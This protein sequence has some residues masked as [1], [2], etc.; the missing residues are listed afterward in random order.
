MDWMTLAVSI[1]SF[2]SM[3]T[4]ACNRRY[5]GTQAKRL[6]RALADEEWL[7]FNDEL[8][9]HSKPAVFFDLFQGGL[10]MKCSNRSF[11][12]S[13]LFA[14]LLSLGTGNLNARD[15]DL[16]SQTFAAAQTAKQQ[17]M[18]TCRA[19]YRDCLSLRQLPSF[20]CRGVYQDCTR[21]TCNVA[22]AGRSSWPRFP[23]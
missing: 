23:S 20:E 6:L 2:G 4:T 19:R 7:Y 10:V 9:R 22:P 1:C 5:Q 11:A 3:R 21:Y 14:L 15:A 13:V 17:C 12:A 8:R 16:T 18:N